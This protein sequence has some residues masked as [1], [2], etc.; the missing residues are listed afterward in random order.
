MGNSELQTPETG[1]NLQL[2]VMSAALHLAAYA[3]P[4]EDRNAVWQVRKD[5]TM[6]VLRQAEMG[7]V[8]ENAIFETPAGLV[9][10]SIHACKGG[11]IDREED[12]SQRAVLLRHGAEPRIF[13]T[14][15]TPDNWRYN[16]KK[17]Q[18]EHGRNVLARLLTDDTV[19]AAA[20]FDE[21]AKTKQLLDCLQQDLRDQETSRTYRNHRKFGIFPLKAI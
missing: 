21:L 14:N 4:T 2:E 3:V 12:A 13:R 1:N 6:T 5:P 8:L 19:S 15:F 11:F 16:F 18:I 7:A 20:S 9:I 17:L 10:S